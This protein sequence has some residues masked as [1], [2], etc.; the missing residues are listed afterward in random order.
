V[1]V[2]GIPQ[3]L[4]DLDRWCGF[5]IVRLP[6]GK[7]K[8]LPLISGMPGKHL[9]KCNDPSTLRPFD[10]ALR[11][12]KARGLELGFA[13]DTDLPYFF[14]DAD[15]CLMDGVLREDVREVH[16]ALGTYTEVSVSGTGLHIIGQ[17]HF[18]PHSASRPVS[19]T[20]KP[21]ERY[22]VSGGRF[23]VLTG[24]VVPG[25]DTI[26]DRTGTLAHLF[27][28][29]APR[30]AEPTRGEG[31]E[32]LASEGRDIIAWAAPFWTDGRRHPMALSLSGV[33]AKA[34]VPAGQARRIIEACA[35]GDADPGAKLA[36]CHDTYEAYAAG[37]DVAGWHGLREA[38]LSS[39][40]L[41]PLEG[42]LEAF[43][44]RVDPPPTPMT[45]PVE[46]L[47]PAWAR[48][49][50]EGAA[51]MPVDPVMIALPMLVGVG[52]LMGNRV[53]IT[54]KDGWQ[55]MGTLFGVIVSPSGTMKTPAFK[56]ARWPMRALQ[57]Q[58]YQDYQGRLLLWEEAHTRWENESKKLRGPEPR[59]PVIR[60]YFTTDATMEAI[61]PMLQ[62]TPGLVYESDEIAGWV[63]RM[64]Q[65]RKGGDRQQWMSIH[66]GEYIKINRKSAEAPIHIE[67]PVV[68]VCG[69]VQPEV[70]A[71]L[72]GDLGNKDGFV[73]RYLPAIPDVIP[74]RWNRNT[75]SADA[76]AGAASLFRAID[77]LPPIGEGEPINVTLSEAAE[78]VWATWH[79]RNNAEAHRLGGALRG[80]YVKLEAHVI[81]FILILHVAD[82]PWMCEQPV[83]AETVHRAI[84]IAEYFR[85][86]IHQFIVLLQMGTG[87]GAGNVGLWSRI[88]R[89]LSKGRTVTPSNEEN[90][91]WVRQRDLLRS[92][93]N[94]TLQE[95]LIELDTYIDLREVDRRDVKLHN[96]VTAEYRIRTVRRSDSLTVRQPNEASNEASNGYRDEELP[97]DDQ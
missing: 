74:K 24:N 81:R 62:H 5:Q 35:A 83:P 75:I 65:Y 3:E 2:A 87:Q 51:A 28:P 34:G 53:Q 58:E 30:K 71:S 77:D 8:K 78:A 84:R 47:P 54:M 15:D 95:L 79:D 85:E 1:N 20:G 86:Q 33:L 13:F 36:A 57:K 26:E 37:V 32:L 94:I 18:P 73:Y 7:T 9:A 44:T 40:D 72:G 67:H 61:A 66:S 38:G 50:S 29:G 92:L 41:A 10:L 88:Q 12:A 97:W 31:G 49:V 46:D 45:F 89:Q 16:E 6:G 63:G 11:D 69:G 43:T 39:A 82:D 52:S 80:F 68:G 42:I 93:G 14:I 70:V 4:K 27:P 59:K 55:D 91:G 22:P 48:Y 56:H 76:Y 60:D 23:C 25:Y 17:G 64:N 96:G 21:L 90:D 19:G